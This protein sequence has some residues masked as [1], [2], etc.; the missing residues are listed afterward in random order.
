MKI[1][2]AA[3]LGHLLGAV[4]GLH[5]P[6]PLTGPAWQADWQA[7]DD[8]QVSGGLMAWANPGNDSAQRKAYQRA[9]DRLAGAGL[10]LLAAGGKRAGLTAEGLKMA[11]ELCGLP[12]LAD[13][14]AGLDFIQAAPDAVRWMPGGYVSE[15][16][17]A[18][19]P[20]TYGQGRWQSRLPDSVLGLVDAVLPL[21]VAGLVEWRSCHYSGVFLYGLTPEGRE[22]AERRRE[23]GETRAGDWPG[24]VKRC[25]TIRTK[26]AAAADAYCDAL[27]A[28]K[29]ARLTAEPPRPNVHQHLDSVD[30]PRA[31]TA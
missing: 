14:L 2:E 26:S 16:T 5:E 4:D 22:M 28:V 13:A 25:R 10:V 27:R 11:R 19:L 12:T 29:D 15:T 3:T 18:G 8:F 30:A 20:P 21:L 17:L 7:R 24:L 9:R 31:A 23:A 6:M 1:N